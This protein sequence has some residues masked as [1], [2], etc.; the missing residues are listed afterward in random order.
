MP[1]LSGLLTFVDEL[2]EHQLIKV[3]V[4]GLI[5]PPCNETFDTLPV[6]NC[7]TFVEKSDSV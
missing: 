7:G 4:L 2:V 1:L 5:G 3:Y 6:K